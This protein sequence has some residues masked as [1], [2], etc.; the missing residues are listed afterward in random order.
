MPTS[1][2]SRH[3]HRAACGLA[4]RGLPAILFG[5]L[6]LAPLLFPSPAAAVDTF[7]V[8]LFDDGRVLATDGQPR[9][10]ADTLRL[11]CFGM[12]EEP[13]ALAPCLAHLLLALDAAEAGADDLE[14]VVDRLLEVE[15]RFQGWSGADAR[16]APGPQLRARVDALL[17][18]YAA[19]DNLARTPGFDGAALRK[20][21]DRVAALPPKERR[22]ELNLLVQQQT[23]AVIWHV[24]SAEL[25]LDEGDESAAVR[26]ADEILRE[27]ADAEASELAAARC[28][29]GRAR[30]EMGSCGPEVIEELRMCSPSHHRRTDVDE[31]L[32]VCLA[33]S[34]RWSEAREALERLPADR[35]DRR[36]I[37]KLQRRIDAALGAESASVREPEPAPEAAPERSAS[38]EPVYA[39]PPGVADRSDRRTEDERD[40]EPPGEMSGMERARRALATE[41]RDVYDDLWPEV[42]KAARRQESTDAR[43]L[44]AS[45]A[46]RMSSWRDAIRY[47][48]DDEALAGERPDLQLEL[49]IALYYAGEI[50]E[51][52]QAF[53]QARP[54]L[55]STAWVGFWARELGAG[56]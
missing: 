50:D 1:A 42:R 20:E 48:E 18:R 12:L 29:R 13:S 40:N 39:P 7:Y 49:A 25:Y 9:R 11:A 47:L 56:G 17:E 2:T 53:E 52:R 4:R 37:K 26:A 27:L 19:A 21:A 22:K 51:A 24:L 43:R 33:G 16:Y 35:R 5:P 45:L 46:F 31:A 36:D 10:A 28:V 15:Q 3:R 32:A 14:A 54:A 41:R 30:A 23:D 8:R 44:A 34:E 38:A 55:S 6:L